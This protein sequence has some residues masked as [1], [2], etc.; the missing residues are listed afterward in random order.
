MAGELVAGAVVLGADVVVVGAGAAV[1]AG[2]DAGF[3]VVVV[4][5]G[6]VEMGVEGPE[7]QAANND[8]V[9]RITIAVILIRYFTHSSI[10]IC[11]VIKVKEGDPE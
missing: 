9:T 3:C 11:L 10:I 5:A 1:T 8:N 6:G 7:L 2:E 4:I